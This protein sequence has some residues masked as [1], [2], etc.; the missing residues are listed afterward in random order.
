MLTALT[1][2]WHSGA[3][4]QNGRHP[5][6]KSL[7]ELGLGDQSSRRPAKW[8]S[9]ASRLPPTSHTRRALMGH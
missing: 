6:R 9:M 5:F 7:A 2:V 4:V 1:G 8:H 3:A